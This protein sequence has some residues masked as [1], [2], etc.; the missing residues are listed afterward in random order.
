MQNLTE[1]KAKGLIII[2]IVILV[3]ITFIG[4]K[5]WHS[6]QNSLQDLVRQTSTDSK[7]TTRLQV[8]ELD[9]AEM[10]HRACV[11]CS[12]TPSGVQDD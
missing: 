4:L 5:P 12:R 9:G 10:H 2:G 7:S 11:I 6:R 8:T 3:V 1:K